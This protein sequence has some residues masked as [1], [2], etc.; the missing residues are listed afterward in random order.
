MPTRCVVE[1]GN[2]GPKKRVC[3]SWV[4]CHPICLNSLLS[5]TRTP[6]P[7]VCAAATN[8]SPTSQLRIEKRKCQVCLLG[9]HERQ[10]QHLWLAIISIWPMAHPLAHLRKPERQ[11][12]TMPTAKL[13]Q[14]QPFPPRN[15]GVCRYH[16]MG[17]F[18]T[19]NHQIFV[20]IDHPLY[21]QSNVD[22][23]TYCNN[24]LWGGGLTPCESS[25][26]L[27]VTLAHVW[28]VEN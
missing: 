25:S 8:P 21:G 23:N 7:E 15:L 3:R 5:L 16:S 12:W 11:P 10:S 1:K 20:T 24:L 28:L 2:M 27:F 6:H 4:G 9:K 22:C 13:Q 26:L 18:G 14:H 17:R 19:E